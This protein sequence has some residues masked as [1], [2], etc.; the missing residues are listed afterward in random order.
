ML[1]CALAC[2]IS[3]WTGRRACL[4]DFAGGLVQTGLPSSSRSPQLAAA[5]TIY[6]D[7]ATVLLKQFQRPNIHLS[8]FPCPRVVF[9][10]THCFFVFLLNPENPR[11]NNA[12]IGT[13]MFQQQGA[14][15]QTVNL[16]C[17]RQLPLCPD[18]IPDSPC[19]CQRECAVGRAS[20]SS[21]PEA[22]TVG[23]HVV[24]DVAA[25]VV[26]KPVWTWYHF[27]L[28][29]SLSQVKSVKT[30]SV[31]W[32]IGCCLSYFYMVRKNHTQTQ[33]RLL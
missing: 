10:P 14:I 21:V 6:C 7:H 4:Q 11:V 22:Q 32:T 12:F 15:K 19:R 33:C 27:L 5:Y 23:A 16:K 9:S 18:V 29:L 28:S 2:F 3:L 30:G 25:H 20:V 8:P 17:R 26:N 24:F 31:F 1:M 13:I